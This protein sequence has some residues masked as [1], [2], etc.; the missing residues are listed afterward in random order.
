LEVDFE[1]VTALDGSWEAIAG[2]QE[3]AWVFWFERFTEI[4]FIGGGICAKAC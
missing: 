4:V 1:V 2:E 3:E